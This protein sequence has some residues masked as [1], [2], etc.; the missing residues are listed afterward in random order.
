VLENFDE[1]SR[2]YVRRILNLTLRI[3]NESYVMLN[4]VKRKILSG[5]L[6]GARLTTDIN[7]IC[8]YT[9]MHAADALAKMYDPSYTI[10]RMQL[11]HGDDY[12]A[13]FA[14]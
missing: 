9:Y 7:T 8:N 1:E 14:S 12:V 2:P 13:V 3:T 6:S 4:D 10:D 5:L 11:Y